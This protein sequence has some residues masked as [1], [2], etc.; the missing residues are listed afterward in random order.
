[1]TTIDKLKASIIG[2]T[3]A[4]ATYAAFAAKAAQDGYEAV[5]DLFEAASKA[6]SIHA[7]NHNKVLEK[8]GEKLPV[9]D[10]E[11]K[12]GSTQDNL[13]HAING[14]KHEFEHMYPDFIATAKSEGEKGAVRSFTWAIET[15]KHHAEFYRIALDAVENNQLDELPQKFWICPLCGDTFASIEGMERCPLCGVKVEDFLIVE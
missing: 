3:T 8:L 10:I 4:S 11:I 7:F 12:V 14:E 1:M 13:K 15:E 6:E 5:Q 9:F 2:E